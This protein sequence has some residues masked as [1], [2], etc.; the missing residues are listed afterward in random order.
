MFLFFQNVTMVWLEEQ[1]LSADS[2]VYGSNIL[3]LFSGK[4]TCAS[5]MQFDALVQLRGRRQAN[6]PECQ[7]R[8]LKC[9]PAF[10]LFAHT[11]TFQRSSSP[12]RTMTHPRSFPVQG[13]AAE[14]FGRL[15]TDSLSDSL[16][17]FEDLMYMSG[18]S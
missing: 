7:T 16:Y 5:L 13:V 11:Q 10:F 18:H 3:T 2:A 14:T 6:F 9:H 17:A 1:P 8:L 4:K 12:A 15:V